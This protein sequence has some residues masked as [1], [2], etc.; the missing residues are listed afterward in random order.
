[1][2][3]ALAIDPPAAG[4]TLAAIERVYRERGPAFLRVA[5]GITATARPRTTQFRT[6]SRSPSGIAPLSR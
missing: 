4:A 2:T 6:A 3:D 1:M 5:T